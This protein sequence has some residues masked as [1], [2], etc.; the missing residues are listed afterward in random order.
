MRVEEQGGGNK[1]TSK[2]T[3][4]DSFAFLLYRHLFLPNILKHWPQTKSV[5]TQ[6]EETCYCDH[7]TSRK[8]WSQHKNRQWPPNNIRVPKQHMHTQNARCGINLVK[9]NPALFYPLVT[10]IRSFLKVTYRSSVDETM[11]IRAARI[12]LQQ[13]KAAQNK[14]RCS[15]LQQQNKALEERCAYCVKECSVFLCAWG[16]ERAQERESV[17][18]PSLE[19]WDGDF[20]FTYL[21]EPVNGRLDA[22]HKSTVVQEM[23]NQNKS[24]HPVYTRKTD[25]EERTIRKKV[26]FKSC[27]VP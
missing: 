3:H 18:H 14:T 5:W 12:T 7:E 27:V 21:P 24:V 10:E 15:H 4:K 9:K 23:L 19:K 8:S 25:G 16:G 26:K 20:F 22:H 6:A 13:Q 17:Y 11:V 1:T 2:K